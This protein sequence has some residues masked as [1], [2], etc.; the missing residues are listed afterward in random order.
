MPSRRRFFRS[1]VAL[2]G[3]RAARADSIGVNEPDKRREAALKLRQDAAMAQSLRGQA[4]QAGNGDQA[5]PRWVACFT[6]GLPHSQLGEVEAGAYESL[7]EAI[8][9]GKHADFERVAR[10]SGRRFV[11]PQ[12]AYAYHLEGT[13]SHRLGCPPPPAFS[14]A[15]AA[16]EMV[17]L[18][19]QALARD[20]SFA[21]YAASPLVRQAAQELGQTPDTVFRGPTPGDRRGPYISQFL[22]KPVSY[23]STPIDQ[24][25]RTPPPGADFMTS[26]SEW[27]Q[28]QTGVPP[29]RPS[30]F[31]E[32]RRYIRNGRD[33]AEY[34][35][36]DFLYQAFLNAALILMNNT[37]EAVLDQNQYWSELNPYK[38]SKA[39]DGFVTFGY[40][41]AVDWLARVTTAAIKAAWCQKWLVHRRT[42]PEEFGARIHQTKTGA[43]SYP[44]HPMVLDSQALEQTRQRFGTHLLPQAYPEG[45][46]LHP[47]YPSGHATVA[48][49]CITALKAL[50]D[51]SALLTNCVEAAADGLSLL[52]CGDHIPTV[53]EELNKLAFNVAMGRNFAGIHYRTDA[54]GGLLLGEEI[55]ISVLQD[56]VLTLNEDF[57]GFRFTRLDGTRTMISKPS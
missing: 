56:L 32:T 15:E 41:M 13:D 14:S 46:P 57:E 20:V 50:F 6:K 2:G 44:I 5:I 51:E 43:A 8:A 30:V 23:G 19:W 26:F 28:I 38:K 33:L 48:G 49:A 10:G 39:Q 21:D 22:L 35:H 36:Y 12:A 45:C 7:L 31:D 3:L 52:P 53:G 29:W 55:A 4:P 34:V 16:A 42:R 24:R 1:L 40:A 11:S 17:E 54:T 9:S 47:A 25:Y 37:P 27:L 18:Y